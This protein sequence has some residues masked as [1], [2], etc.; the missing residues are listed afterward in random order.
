[1]R[2]LVRQPRVVLSFLCLAVFVGLLGQAASAETL[3]VGNCKAGSQFPNISYAI[4]ASTPGSTIYICPGTYAEQLL[5][6]QNLTLIGVSSNG[7]SGASAAGPNNPVIT[8]P[9]IG[10][11][12]A[13]ATDLSD[14]SA[15]A[16]QIAVLTPEGASAPIKVNI[17]N[18]A[19]DGANNLI[20][21][22]GPDL[23]GIYY[24][25]ASGTIDDV[26]ARNQE[27]TASLGGCQSGLAIFVQSGYASGGTAV[28]TVENSS[29]HAYQKNGITV[30][31]SGTV[32]AISGNYVVGQGST[33]VI[34]QNGIQVSDGARGSLKTNTVTDD[35]YINPSNCGTACYGASGILVYDSGATSASHL[36]VS[37]NTI[38]NTQLPIVVYGDSLGTADY[39]DVTSNKITAAQAAGTFLDD[40]IDLCSNNNTATSNTVFNTSG[41]GIHIDSTCTESTGTTGNNTTV[42][43][44]TINEACAG[45]LTG[46]GTGS[47]QSANIFYNVAQVAQAGDSCPSGSPATALAAA[48]TRN[49]L[50]PLPLHH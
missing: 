16:A 5:I 14:G 39:N 28:V 11:V 49:K 24:Q 47:S 1:M 36:A 6:T 8:S 26:V 27:L 30:D 23:V 21:G 43:K 20:P 34:A 35:V 50:N 42:T 15:I 44:N 38:S 2:A 29:V 12:T 40:G 31:G 13:N 45:V 32:A 19:V 48:T 46:S 7:L 18:I 22:C 4:R 37:G 3:V 25:N 10:G 33:P 17:S 41:S 9:T